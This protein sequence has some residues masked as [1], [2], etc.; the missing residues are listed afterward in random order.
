MTVKNREL[1]LT[2]RVSESAVMTRGIRDVIERIR[3]SDNGSIIIPVELGNGY[4]MDNPAPCGTWE[5]VS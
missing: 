3:L 4:A 5:R 1:L 2:F